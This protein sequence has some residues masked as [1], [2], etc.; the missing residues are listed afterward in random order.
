MKTEN[1]N[2]FVTQETHKKLL[3]I[4]EFMPVDIY[5]KN[6]YNKNE[7]GR[8]NLGYK[9]HIRFFYHQDVF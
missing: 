7:M 1:I 6:E 4:P 9:R 3:N 8:I 2:V 5:P